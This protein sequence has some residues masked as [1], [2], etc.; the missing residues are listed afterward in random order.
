VGG[1]VPRQVVPALVLFSGGLEL[2]SKPFPLFWSGLYHSNRE[3]NKNEVP[4]D[5]TAHSGLG[6]PTSISNKEISHG[7]DPMVSEAYPL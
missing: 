5:S 7:V 1:A 2:V 3:A 4:G 6:P